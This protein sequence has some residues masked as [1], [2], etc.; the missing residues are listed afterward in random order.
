VHRRDVDGKTLLHL[1]VVVRSFKPALIQRIWEMNP[2]AIFVANHLGYTP[3]DC[4]IRSV[5][6][7]AIEHFQWKL[8]IWSVEES[9]VKV[10]QRTSYT[11]DQVKVLHQREQ[12]FREVAQGECE[13]PLLLL[14]P[15]DC[16]HLISDYL[17]ISGVSLFGSG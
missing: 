4:A 1:V 6:E 8:S 7:W 12:R 3:F 16:V 15:R 13:R 11:I 2:D 9:L 14:L 17:F 5:N 10:R